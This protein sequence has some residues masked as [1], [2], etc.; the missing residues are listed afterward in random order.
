MIILQLEI[1]L[2][3]FEDGS[4]RDNTISVV[5][6]CVSFDSVKRTKKMEQGG[7]GLHTY[8]LII[9]DVFLVH[10]SY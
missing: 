10:S 2:R 1:R 4:C 8:L 9:D 3:S 6:L 5:L 7:T